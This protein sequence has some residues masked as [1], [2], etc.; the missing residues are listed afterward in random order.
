MPLNLY[1]YY[2]FVFF[3]TGII[4]TTNRETKGWN[5][6]RQLSEAQTSVTCQ[7]Y[8][9]QINIFVYFTNHRTS[10]LNPYTICNSQYVMC[11]WWY[12]TQYIFPTTALLLCNMNLYDLLPSSPHKQ[13]LTTI[14]DSASSIPPSYTQHVPTAPLDKTTTTMQQISRQTKRGHSLPVI[15]IYTH[16]NV[17]AA[18]NVFCASELSR[19][20]KRYYACCHNLM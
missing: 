14:C 8:R 4:F 17:P 13:I 1:A 3:L 19:P 16:S 20:I 6:C 15:L 11:Y 18:S 5:K 10:Y 7:V 9:L 2:F 12:N